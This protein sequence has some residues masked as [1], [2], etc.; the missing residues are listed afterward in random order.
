M[1]ILQQTRVCSIHFTP[2]SFKEIAEHLKCLGENFPRKIRTL[3]PDAVL[4]EN[5]IFE[6]TRGVFSFSD[7]NDIALTK[8]CENLFS[9]S[10]R[11]EITLNNVERPFNVTECSESQSNVQK[12]GD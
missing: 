5:L 1:Q 4:T 12:D 6:E 2:H 7:K 3:L 11:N 9:I 8:N 10:D